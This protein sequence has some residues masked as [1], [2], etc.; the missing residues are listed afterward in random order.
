MYMCK[1]ARMTVNMC[2]WEKVK[3]VEIKWDV[4]LKREQKEKNGN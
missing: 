1:F 3:I 4:D 2:E